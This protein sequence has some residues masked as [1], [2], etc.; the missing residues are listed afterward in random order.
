MERL[1]CR[2]D[3]TAFEREFSTDMARRGRWRNFTPTAGQVRTMRSI[4]TARLEDVE[5]IDTA[6]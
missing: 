4:V 3:V 5:V 2:T 1:A 6:A